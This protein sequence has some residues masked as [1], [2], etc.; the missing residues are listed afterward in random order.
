MSAG[1]QIKSE[2]LSDAA[3]HRATETVTALNLREGECDF[4]T[5]EGED[6]EFSVRYFMVNP[7]TGGASAACGKHAPE[8]WFEDDF[9]GEVYDVEDFECDS[10]RPPVEDGEDFDF[11]TPDR[12]M[13]ADNYDC[14]FSAAILFVY[15]G[16][17]DEPHGACLFHARKVWAAELREE[18]QA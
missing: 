14:E 7:K 16:T 6:C 3:S 12:P 10:K 11:Q 17:D 13:P 9:G 1:K 15:P 5:G 8:M 2:I 4:S 18:K